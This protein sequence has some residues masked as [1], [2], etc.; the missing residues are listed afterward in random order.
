MNDVTFYRNTVI[1]MPTFIILERGDTMKP[2]GLSAVAVGHLVRQYKYFNRKETMQCKL[3]NFLRFTMCTNKQKLLIDKK[4]K[5]NN[6]LSSV[7]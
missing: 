5:K 3:K 6:N 1:A 2:T 4:R 7:S